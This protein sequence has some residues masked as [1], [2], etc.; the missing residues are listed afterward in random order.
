MEVEM[1]SAFE[2]LKLQPVARQAAAACVLGAAGAA[3]A[4]VVNLPQTFAVG[5]ASYITV[6]NATATVPDGGVGNGVLNPAYGIADVS[7]VGGRGD[8]FDGAL[9]ISVNGTA[10]QQPGNQVDRSATAA[11]VFL[12]TVAPQRIGDIDTRLNYFMS[13]SGPI[14]RVFGSFTNTSA[15]TQSV[16]VGYGGNLG[17]DGDTT[18]Q[19]ASNGSTS[20]NPAQ[21]RWIVSDD[22]ANDSDAKLTFVFFGAGGQAA[23][24]GFW[25]GDALG[26]VGERWIL[27]I[28]PGETENLLWFVRLSS[29]IAGALSGTSIF[30]DRQSLDAAGL[31]AGLSDADLGQTSN[32]VFDVGG[33]VPEPASLA[34]F[35]V[36]GLAAGASGRKRKKAE[37]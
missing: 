23:S 24:S 31:L 7:L 32:W 26:L 10:F 19:A 13:A 3:Q 9:G 4:A 29:D 28:D 34:L 27:N 30:D 8:A 16:V 21:Q 37:S 17:S 20:F 11:G 15:T 1:N 14:V 5:G 2:K 12:N 36:G 18:I 25:A 33:T 22:G 6:S 35:G